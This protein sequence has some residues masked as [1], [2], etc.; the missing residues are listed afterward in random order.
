M[1][2]Q[3]LVDANFDL[4]QNIL[5]CWNVTTDL[6]E[7]VRDIESGDCSSEQALEILKAYAV[8]YEN[9][10][11]HAWQL[12]ETVCS[13][14]H[15]LHQNNNEPSFDPLFDTVVEMQQNKGKKSSKKS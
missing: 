5:R 3:T 12:Y 8:V 15:Q 2:N 13:G 11:N 4:E 10:F 14:L 7:L 9:R 1:K 6:A